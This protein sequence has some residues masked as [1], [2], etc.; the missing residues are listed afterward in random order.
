MKT[1]ING[2]NYNFCVVASGTKFYIEAVH[3]SSL[4]FSF[5]NNLN[6][7]LSEFDIDIDDEKISE[8]QWIASERKNKLFY[9]KAIKFLSDKTYRDYLEKNLEEDRKCGEWENRKII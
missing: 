9:G 7:I 8:S 6:A 2:Q 1:K 4:R 5:I 3:I